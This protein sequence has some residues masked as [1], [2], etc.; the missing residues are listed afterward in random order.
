MGHH[1]DVESPDPVTTVDEIDRQRASLVLE[2]AFVAAQLGMPSEDHETA[3]DL[4]RIQLGALLVDHLAPDERTIEYRGSHRATIEDHWQRMVTTA[5]THTFLLGGGFVQP[6]PLLDAVVAH[7]AR[8]SDGSGAVHRPPLDH[9]RLVLGVLED[10]AV[11]DATGRA[12]RM[13]GP[14]DMAALVDL[15]ALATIGAVRGD[16]PAGAPASPAARR[17]GRWS[18]STATV[19]ATFGIPEVS[20]IEA[21][22]DGWVCDACGCFFAGTV[23]GAVA[24]PD[25]FAPVGRTGPCDGSIEC[26]CHAAPVRREIR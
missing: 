7:L 13:A 10:L 23:D 12:G 2:R 6:D 4:L 17:R 9:G 20:L 8:A 18:R 26:A 5:V 3:V 16:P 19:A 1:T 25:R 14:A 22:K 24:H 11:F 15:V 21:T